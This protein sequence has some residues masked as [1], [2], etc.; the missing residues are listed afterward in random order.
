MW[1]YDFGGDSSNI[2]SY[3]SF[4]RRKIDDVDPKLIQTVRGV[5]YMLQR[6]GRPS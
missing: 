2:E 4:L 3:I 6:E 5:G 1:D